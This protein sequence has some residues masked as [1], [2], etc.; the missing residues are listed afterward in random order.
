MYFKSPLL[1]LRGPGQEPGVTAGLVVKWHK[2]G[3]PLPA[4]SCAKESWSAGQYS[5][6]EDLGCKWSRLFPLSTIF[7]HQVRCA[8]RPGD[9]LCPLRHSPLT[10]SES[11]EF[12]AY[13]LRML[14]NW[15]ITSSKCLIYLG[16]CKRV[17][18]ERVKGNGLWRL[19][20]W[21]SYQRNRRQ[22]MH[23]FC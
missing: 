20:P 22:K 16:S 8:W 19:S 7:T 21:G 14:S 2:S 4:D 17:G 18:R 3:W 5:Q 1:A 15:V 23:T 13:F 6:Q 11:R 9:R 12:L 10:T